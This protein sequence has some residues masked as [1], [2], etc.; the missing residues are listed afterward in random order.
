[1]KC[2]RWQQLLHLFFRNLDCLA[3][4]AYSLYTDMY[5]KLAVLFMLILF[6]HSCPAGGGGVGS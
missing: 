5:G 1:M 4:F 6:A 2:E 3:L